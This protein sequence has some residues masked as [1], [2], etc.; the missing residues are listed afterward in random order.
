MSAALDVDVP[1]MFSL[2]LEADLSIEDAGA[3]KYVEVLKM[4]EA[5]T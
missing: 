4:Q 5:A 3:V 2:T 1:E